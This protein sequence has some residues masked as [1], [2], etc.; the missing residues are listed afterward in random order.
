MNLEA[1]GEIWARNG[2]VG[3]KETCQN[4]GEE[5]GGRNPEEL[6]EQ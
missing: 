6:H 4:Q 2:D 1:R 5:V 3:K